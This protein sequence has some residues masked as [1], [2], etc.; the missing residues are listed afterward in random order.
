MARQQQRKQ[1][2]G[3]APPAAVAA[4]PTHCAP[5]RYATVRPA[6]GTCLLPEELNAVAVATLPD[7]LGVVAAPSPAAKARALHAALGTRPGDDGALAALP[8]VR[9]DP[10][11][12][13][14]FDRA[15]RPERPAS[16]AR[17]PKQW[18]SSPD[19]DRVMRQYT[20]SH[21][22]FAYLGALPMD[23]EAVL[24]AS[25]GECVSRTACAAHVVSLLRQGKTHLAAV[26]NLDD[27]TQSGSHWVACAA[28][29]DPAD[30]RRFG[31]WYY[32]SVGRPPTREVRAFMRRLRGEVRA[33]LGQGAA[34]RFRIHWNSTRKQW[35]N[36]E[37]GIYAM[38]FNIAFVTTDRPVRDICAAMRSDGQTHSLRRVLFRDGARDFFPPPR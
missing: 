26:L 2:R 10:R 27:H 9:A 18:L 33:A 22:H 13:A 32:D 11:L 15:M 36:T 14:L 37:C 21:P 12:R 17:N 6:A 38:L 25:T 35:Q 3:G 23:F 31:L 19:I 8:H 1:Q 7:P 34:A 28:G 4:A 29:L 24:D 16:W 5:A 20:A 30:K